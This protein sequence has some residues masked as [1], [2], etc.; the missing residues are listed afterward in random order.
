[1]V[2]IWWRHIA[3]RQPRPAPHDR[4]RQD[5]GP[6]LTLETLESRELPALM[7]WVGSF[8]SNWSDAR[9][10]SPSRPGP[11]DTA[12]FDGATARNGTAITD[13]AGLNVARVEMR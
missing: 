13:A 10:W 4:R 7:S 5:R 11:A 8:S 12:V 3:N 2:R 6:R 9:N 1:M